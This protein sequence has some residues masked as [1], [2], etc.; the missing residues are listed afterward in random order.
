MC[1]FGFTKERVRN[2]CPV[3]FYLAAQNLNFVLRF[4]LLCF[5]AF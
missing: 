2:N 5:V 4:S 3:W 1:N